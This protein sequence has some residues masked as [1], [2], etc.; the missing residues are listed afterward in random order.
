[1]RLAEKRIPADC[2]VQRFCEVVNQ[3]SQGELPLC[4]NHAQ[5][6]LSALTADQVLSYSE[7]M[8][9][10]LRILSFKGLIYICIF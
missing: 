6:T 5:M 2:V 3:H 10:D 1:M 4:H 8:I 9:S 7:N